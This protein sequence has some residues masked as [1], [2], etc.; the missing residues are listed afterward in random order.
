[1]VAVHLA[2][3]LAFSRDDRDDRG[4]ADDAMLLIVA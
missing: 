2:S 3:F 4:P 1:M